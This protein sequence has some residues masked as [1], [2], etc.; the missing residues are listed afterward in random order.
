MG[1]PGLYP[2]NLAC[3]TRPR[4]Y[5]WYDRP[6]FPETLR[7]MRTP[8]PGRRL[9]P[10]KQFRSVVPAFRARPAGKPTIDAADTFALRTVLLWRPDKDRSCFITIGAP[11]PATVPTDRG[12]VGILFIR[13]IDHLLI[14]RPHQGTGRVRPAARQ[15]TGTGLQD[16][17]QGILR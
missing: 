16:F 3:R 10:V 2:F 11:D 9:I 13:Y 17:S 14:H 5:R 8:S 1:Q 12:L 4:F 6:V 7:G 15:R